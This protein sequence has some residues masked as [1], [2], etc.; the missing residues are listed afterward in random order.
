MRKISRIMRIV[1]ASLLCL[2]FATSS[3]VSNTFAK[4]TTTGTGAP[5]SARVAVWGFD[6]DAGTDLNNSYVKSD[7]ETYTIKADGSNVIAP[8]T[9]GNL[10]WISVEGTPE[11][12]YDVD[13]S[14]QITIGDGYTHIIDEIG[15]EI[16]YFPIAIYLYRYDY[17]KNGTITKKTLARRHCI[18]RLTPDAPEGMT[19]S[20]SGD[21][22]VAIKLGMITKDSPT[23]AVN[24]AKT[25]IN[26]LYRLSLFSS[27]RWTNIDTLKT[28][29]NSQSSSDYSISTMLDE[30]NLP[31]S[32]YKSSRY[33]I[34]WDWAYNNSTGPQKKNTDNAV[35]T[36]LDENGDSYTYCTYQTK[37][38]DTK[39]GEAMLKNPEDFQITISMSVS[40]AQ[41]NTVS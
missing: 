34:G 26:K 6:I 3:M 18:V 14:G 10:A 35:K 19:L 22:D 40:I 4:Y 41:I 32:Q 20:V 27:S 5:S 28:K 17:N 16:N 39:L 25:E 30:K 9:S 23:D 1:T 33:A 36:R 7:G 2:T 11:V 13:I 21:K 24:D 12:A 29:L 31:P 37:E 15:R 8:G 38:L